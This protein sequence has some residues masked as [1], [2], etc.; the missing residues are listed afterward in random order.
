MGPGAAAAPR[1]ARLPQGWL[2]QPHGHT[3]GPLVYSGRDAPLWRN[4]GKK[5]AGPSRPPRPMHTESGSVPIMDL[6]EVILSPL[7]FHGIRKLL[8]DQREW[9]EEMYFT[10][11]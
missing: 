7:G 3:C 11:V 9:E 1:P 10:L 6:T 8:P 5:A 2:E 4:T